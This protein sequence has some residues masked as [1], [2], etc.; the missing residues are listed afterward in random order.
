MRQLNRIKAK[1]TLHGLNTSDSFVNELRGE[2]EQKEEEEKDVYVCRYVYIQN[3]QIKHNTAEPLK[4]E[5][6][7]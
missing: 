5:N 6:Q 2:G 4:R 1:C 7:V 3:L